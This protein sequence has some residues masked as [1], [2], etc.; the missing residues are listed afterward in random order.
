MNVLVTTSTF[1]RW[2]NDPGPSFVFDLCR[3]LASH[4]L[5]I[6]VLA[7]HAEGTQK[8]E[9]MEGIKVYRYQYLPAAMEGVSY[10]GGIL[11]RLRENKWGVWQVPFF[12]LAQLRS[13]GEIVRREKIDVI[14]AHWLIPQGLVAAVYKKFFNRRIKLVCTSHGS[15]LMALKGF[16]FDQMKKFVVRQT[17]HVTVVSHALKREV[18]RLVPGA[19]IEVLPMGVDLKR[20]TPERY[21]GE[22]KR[23]YSVEGPF[24]LFVGRLSEEK[25]LEYLLNA[26]PQIIK[27]FPSV[28]LLVVGSGVL[29]DRLKMICVDLNIR[30]RVVFVGALTHEALA[31]YYATADV[32]IGPSLREGFGLVFAEALACECA[33]V[34][35]DLPGIVDIIRDGKTG[36]L[37]RPADS[38]GIADQVT[39]LLA[40]KSSAKTVARQGRQYVTEHFSWDM[41]GGEYARLLNGAYDIK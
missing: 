23:K 37:V 27:S 13:L 18:E 9:V 15:D 38:R 36:F 33:V 30:E 7:P 41:V 34:A 40:D 28:K 25:G 11:A 31:S 35:S 4:G 20:F 5:N 29:E 21:S 8:L 3:Q 6:T 26:M 17:D 16:L 12:L 1:P 2:R 24:L 22:I 10:D 32:L 14:H 19:P 39:R